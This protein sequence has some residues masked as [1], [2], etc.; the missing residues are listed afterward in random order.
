MAVMTK[1]RAVLFDFLERAGWS[2]GQVFF[3]TLLAGGSTV[4]AAD[5]PWRY[6]LTLAL[7]AALLSVILTA[8]Q[9]ANETW[10]NLSFWP[11]LGVRMAKTFLGSFGASAIAD[12]VFDVTTFHWSTA[13]NIA[14]VATISALGK[15]LLA[16][17][18][19]GATPESGSGGATSANPSTLPIETYLRAV[20]PT[21]ATG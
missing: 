3:A 17:E 1:R 18:P 10:K 4:S 21:S 16:R 8:V 11:D 5:L 15:G 20:G 7:S 13:F 2:A 6:A 9:Y 14:V 19:A 12:G